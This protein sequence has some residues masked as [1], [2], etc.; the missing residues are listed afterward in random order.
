MYC[1]IL[2]YSIQFKLNFI[3]LV[4]KKTHDKYVE[5]QTKKLQWLPTTALM[6][7]F[8][9]KPNNN[10]RKGKQGLM[11]VLYKIQLISPFILFIYICVCT[12]V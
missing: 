1:I 12:C 11:I 5:K 10:L 9:N 8:N 3:A 4:K 7:M 2:K 6:S